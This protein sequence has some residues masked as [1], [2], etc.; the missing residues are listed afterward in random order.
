MEVL[1]TIVRVG[2]NETM[3]EEFCSRYKFR[4]SPK[5]RSRVITFKTY[6]WSPDASAV[7]LRFIAIHH[8]ANVIEPVTSL[9]NLFFIR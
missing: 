2:Y 4:P 8:F 7:H 3:A 9:N 1:L 6:T 5:F